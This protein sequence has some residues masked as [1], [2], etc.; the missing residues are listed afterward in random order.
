MNKLYDAGLTIVIAVFILTVVG[1]MAHKAS[2]KKHHTGKE[3]F[4][5]HDC[6]I[7]EVCEDVLEILGQ[8][9][10]DLTP[11]STEM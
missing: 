6:V 2:K 3:E 9:K 10:T 1:G 11:E 7:E 8:G 5:G 4:K